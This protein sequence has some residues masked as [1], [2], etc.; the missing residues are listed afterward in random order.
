MRDEEIT[1]TFSLWETWRGSREFLTPIVM[2]DMKRKKSV[3]MKKIL[4]TARYPIASSHFILPF[5]ISTSPI[6]SRNLDEIHRATPQPGQETCGFTK[7]VGYNPVVVPHIPIS[8][9]HEDNMPITNSVMFRHKEW[10]DGY[11]LFSEKFQYK[12]CLP[13]ELSLHHDKSRGDQAAA[14]L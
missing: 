6:F 9:W 14:K 5:L 3:T 12:T 8:R 11:R 13:A 2:K 10:N 4:Y 7:K 1:Y